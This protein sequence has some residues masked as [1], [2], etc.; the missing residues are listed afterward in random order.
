MTLIE[1]L[2]KA[3]VI[4]ASDGYP[5]PKGHY[6]SWLDDV[7]LTPMLLKAEKYLNS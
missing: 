4:Y 6:I 7:D 1:A 3:D 2:I 5:Y